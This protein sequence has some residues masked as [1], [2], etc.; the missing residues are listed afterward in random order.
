MIADRND[1]LLDPEKMLP[2]PQVELRLVDAHVEGDELIQLF[3]AG[4]RL[5]P[6]RLPKPEEKNTMYYR[7]GT[8][9]MGKLLMIDADMQVV[10]TDP[11]DPFDFF[12]D[13][14]NEELV[15]GFSRNEPNYGLVVYMRDFEDVGKPARPGERLVKGR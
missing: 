15:E 6:L 11:S 14:Y 10:D 9:R 1:L 8:L 7:G 12:I 2:P 3:D 13:R 4:R 5:P